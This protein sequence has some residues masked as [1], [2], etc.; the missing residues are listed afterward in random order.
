MGPYIWALHSAPP[1]VGPSFGALCSALPL[2]W[3][4]VLGLYIQLHLMWAL[5]WVFMFKSTSCRPLC[6]AFKFSSTSCGLLFWGFTPSCRPLY[7][8]FTR[9]KL[10]LGPN[11]SK[12]F[13][14]MWALFMV[15]LRTSTVTLQEKSCGID[16]GKVS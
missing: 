15:K 16:T 8:G 6:W 7:R 14:L 2:T 5:I 13:H 9:I 10:L 4:L 11:F 12:A 3:A 1:H